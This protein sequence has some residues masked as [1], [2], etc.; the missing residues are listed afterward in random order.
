MLSVVDVV[1]FRVLPIFV[2]F[3]VVVLDKLP[4]VDHATP[5]AGLDLLHFDVGLEAGQIGAH[6][7]LHVAHPASRLLDQ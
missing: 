2:V 6:G 5:G 7:A 1:E 3:L 4:V